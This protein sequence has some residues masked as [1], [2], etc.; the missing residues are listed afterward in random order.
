MTGMRTMK[1]DGTTSKEGSEF[2]GV[3]SKA[4][5]TEEQGEC[6][7]GG[8]KQSASPSTPPHQCSPGPP[9]LGKGGRGDSCVRLRMKRS[10][11]T[12]ERGRW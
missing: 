3:E 2:K 1:W 11:F 4:G 12:L 7:V 9:V 8:G 6:G 10:L 5:S